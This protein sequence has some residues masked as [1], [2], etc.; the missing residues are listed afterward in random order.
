MWDG[1]MTN[2]EGVSYIAIKLCGNLERGVSREAEGV[3]G[4]LYT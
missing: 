2:L 3:P 1:G 4:Y